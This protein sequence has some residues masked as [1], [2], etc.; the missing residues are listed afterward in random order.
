M[1]WNTATKLLYVSD[2]TL[3]LIADLWT[4]SGTA[5]TPV[6]T[7]KIIYIP[8]PITGDLSAIGIG[9]RTV[10]ARLIKSVTNDYFRI[11]I[12]AL[13]NSTPA[14]VQD[15]VTKPSWVLNLFS[16]PSALDMFTIGRTA[17]GGA[18]PP[19]LLQLLNNGELYVLGAPAVSGLKIGTGTMKSR[20]SEQGAGDYQWRC[21]ISPNN[22]V[23]DATKPALAL[24]VG[25]TYDAL[26]FFRAA[27]G[28]GAAFSEVFQASGAGNLT[29]TGATA[30]KASGT[31]WANPSDRRLKD[32]IEYYISGL[33]EI[34]RLQPRTFIYN[35]K[36]GSAKGQRGF[37]FIADEIASVMPE[38][39]GTRS[40]KL[41]PDDEEETEIQTLDQ[42]NLILAL[43]N[44]VKELT[45]RVVAL[46]AQL[47][48]S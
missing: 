43:V 5:L 4:I 27:A 40:V 42:S 12:N 31:T 33:N 22:I 11:S 44:A 9:S 13:L 48:K 25:P 29:I 3:W 26:S 36:G 38:T 35:G 18:F 37:G 6:D 41:E 30:T 17:P 47:A 15:D 16:D 46:E 1:Y 39:V 21:N 24:R 19:D 10:K 32:E 34:T 20:L 8:G 28:S 14:W 7:T 45:A 23:D 2:G